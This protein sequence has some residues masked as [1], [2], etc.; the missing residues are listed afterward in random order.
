MDQARG[1]ARKC[2]LVA[3]ELRRNE[4]AFKAFVRARLPRDEADEALQIAAIR[5]LERADSLEDESRVRA[6]LYRLHRN[7]IV[8]LLRKRTSEQRLFSQGDEMPEQSETATVDTCDCSVVQSKNIPP[9]YASILGL[10]DIHG[11]SL[12]EAANRIGIS[13]N[14]ATVRLHRARAA[15]KQRMLEHCGVSSLSECATC[16]CVYEGCC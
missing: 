14:N 3:E 13:V 16:R 5:A 10:V 2:E 9:N 6:W 15:L 7:I 8:D 1:V 11:L 12:R 4:A